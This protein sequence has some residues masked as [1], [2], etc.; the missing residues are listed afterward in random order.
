VLLRRP[1]TEGGGRRY[2]RSPP[3]DASFAPT[4]AIPGVVFIGSVL[5]GTLRAY[6][7]ATGAKLASL[8]LPGGFAVASAPA[9]VDG[10]VIV[11][12]GVGARSADPE[13]P[14]NLA[15]Y[16]PQPVTAFCV[17]GTGACEDTPLP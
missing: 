3:A 4:S 9:V 15:S 1:E 16:M 8:V 2:D 12:A 6:D 5:S 10:L 14:A 17:P 11:G 13:D 7:A